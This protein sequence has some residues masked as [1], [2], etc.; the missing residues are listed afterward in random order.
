[1]PVTRPANGLLAKL[2]VDCGVQQEG[3]REVDGDAW[4]WLFR[5]SQLAAGNPVQVEKA[6]AQA[7]QMQPFDW[8]LVWSNDDTLT[9]PQPNLP[10]DK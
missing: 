2:F 5:S 6:V 9:S 3:G 8:R 4:K 10:V 1:M 7:G